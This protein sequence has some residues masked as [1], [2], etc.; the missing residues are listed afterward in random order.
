MNLSDFRRSRGAC[1][2]RRQPNGV[3]RAGQAPRLLTLLALLCVAAAPKPADVSQLSLE[4]GLSLR[5]YDLGE[6]VRRLPDLVEG[7][8]GNVNTRVDTPDLEDADFGLD[9]QF[10]AEL[11]GFLLID[12]PGEYEFELASDDGS[13]FLL[14]GRVVIGHD[15]L[16][17]DEILM[18]AAVMLDAGAYA[19]KLRHFEAGGGQA[20]RLKWR[21]PG[22]DS[23]AVIPADALR[24]E[25]DQVRVVS[26][27]TK[28]F[29]VPDGQ[30]ENQ[31]RPG[32]RSPLAGVHPA[33]KLV[34]LRPPGFE[35]KVGGMDF[36]PDGR[37][38]LCTWD[39]QGDV[40]VLDGVAGD[41]KDV[42]VTRFAT[43]LAEPLG[44]KV[45]DGR[46]FVLQKQELTELIDPDGDGTADE[47]RSVASGWPVTDNFHEFAFGLA[48]R[49]GKLLANLAVAI[50]PGGKTTVPQVVGRGTAIAIDPDTGSYETVAAGLRTPNGIGAGVDGQ[51]FIAD[52]QGD[53]MPSSKLVHLQDG[54]FYNSYLT[55]PHPFSDRPVTP[56]AVW[57]PHG[58]IGNSPTNPALIPD[59]WGPYAG[60]MVH[61]DVT[62]GGVKRVFME[63]VGD[64]YQGAVFRFTQGLEAGPNRIAF[65]PGG[66]LYVGG[67]GSNGN[68]QHAGRKWFGLQK[69]RYDGEVPF[70]MLAVRPGTGGVEIEFTKPV[71]EDLSPRSFRLRDW[72]YEPT[73]EYGGPKIDQRVLDVASVTRSDDGR[74]VWLE[75]ADDSQLR[76]G[77]HVVYVN[78]RDSGRDA[79]RSIT[80]EEPWQTEAWYT[81]NVI[82]DR[83]PEHAENDGDF[84]VLFDGTEDSARANWRGYKRDS[85]PDGWTVD[86]GALHRKAGGGDIISKDQYGDF[87][88]RL[89]WK[90]APGGNSGIFYRVAET[91][92]PAFRTGVEMQVLDDAAHGDGRSPLTSAGAMYGLFAVPDPSPVRPAGEWNDARIVVEN[93]RVRHY[94]NGRLVVDVEIGGDEWN[95]AIAASKFADWDGF[96]GE[97]RGHIGLQDHGDAVW[98][99]DVR[100]KPLDD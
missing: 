50:D 31:R 97:D 53:W 61:G 93:G 80:G 58:E 35:P 46:V 2:A 59:G 25:A 94:L 28:Q 5:V 86:D 82:P 76:E 64:V 81:L 69:L 13:E 83:R 95:R 63:K 1:P 41:A 37:L 36:L 24:T 79:V 3:R 6:G 8:T 60:H 23:F 52:N 29:T 66:D 70:E 56:P 65:G 68:W 7:Q 54:A 45:L 12:R 90:V 88:L 39:P 14:G 22:A 100:I 92:G 43:G 71:A 4:P 20:L 47:Y 85:L 49:D 30:L 26:P 77:G 57:L 38:V 48:E 74:R 42:T 15:G 27:G 99:R 19:L 9:D 33:L 11:D 91:D 21:P 75:L 78:L 89:R 73:A 55:P 84:E 44:L 98:F 18:D 40:F 96:A 32:D 87:D 16:H 17:D 67:V 34:D 72:R 10:Y 62:H 51:V